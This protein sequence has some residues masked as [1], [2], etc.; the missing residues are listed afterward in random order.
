MRLTV[1]SIAVDGQ[2][3][4]IDPGTISVRGAAGYPLIAHNSVDRGAEIASQDESQGFFSGVTTAAS[5]YNRTQSQVVTS[6][7]GGFSSTTTNPPPDIA[8][9]FLQGAAGAIAQNSQQRSQRAIQEALSRPSIWT[10]DPG[11][12]VQIVVNKPVGQ[13]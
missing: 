7:Y 1:A 3:T 12:K 8:A 5:L 13:L 6:G 11:A 9:G 10:L 4:P 2:D